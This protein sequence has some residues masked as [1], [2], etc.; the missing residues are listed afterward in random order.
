[1][2]RQSQLQSGTG[3]C[4]VSHADCKM[5]ALGLIALQRL[6]GIGAKRTLSV[7]SETPE[8]GQEF[9]RFV[10][11]RFP[12]RTPQECSRAWSEACQILQRCD[13]LGVHAIPACDHVNYPAR[14]HVLGRDRPPVIYVKGTLNAANSEPGVVAIV[15][16]RK[17]TENGVK[18][19]ISFGSFAA[20]HGIPVVSGLAYGCDYHAH[21]GCL[22]QQGIAVAV[23]AHGLDTVYPP[24][25]LGL[26]EEIVQNGGCL[27]S[28]Y[29]PGT[30]A[31]RWNF[32]HR[33]RLQSALSDLVIVIQTGIRGGTLHTVRAAQNQDR[34]VVCVRPSRSDSDTIQV[35]GNFRIVR[36]GVANW[37]EQAPEMLS[38]LGANEKGVSVHSREGAQASLFAES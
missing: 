13:K 19:A 34:Q 1:M 22:D 26:A 11:R 36:E 31:S 9:E 18:A 33:D 23:L 29:P 4:H 14:L 38:L 28:E 32:V 30:R 24:E 12:G 21:A 10:D 37:I 25:H 3:R 15:G 20:L 16:T 17:P 27:V 5:D 6:R 2:F 7:L 35:A 8:S